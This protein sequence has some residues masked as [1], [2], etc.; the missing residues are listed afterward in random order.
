MKSLSTG[1]SGRASLQVTLWCQSSERVVG[2]QTAFLI[3]GD[4][5]CRVSK[6]HLKSNVCSMRAIRTFTFMSFSFVLLTCLVELLEL[7]RKSLD[8]DSHFVLLFIYIVEFIIIIIHQLKNILFMPWKKVTRI[9]ML[10]WLWST[11]RTRP[12][13]PRSFVSP[14]RQTGWQI[15]S[16]DKSREP[17]TDFMGYNAVASINMLILWLFYYLCYLMILKR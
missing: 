7:C 2:K 11:C 17:V 12:S 16:V 4:I 13:F 14:S 9:Q 10:D 15:G 8:I 1:I 5:I 3:S 6:P